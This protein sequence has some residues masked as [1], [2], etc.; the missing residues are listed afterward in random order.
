MIVNHRIAAAVV[1]GAP[2]SEISGLTSGGFS[3]AVFK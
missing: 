3:I 1:G 2:V